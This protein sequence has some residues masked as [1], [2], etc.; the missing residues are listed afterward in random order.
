MIE[1]GRT[2]PQEGPVDD[3]EGFKAYYLSHDVFVLRDV[4]AR[5]ETNG[6]GNSILGAFYVKP[7]FPGRCDHICNH[8]FL[9]PSKYRGKGIGSFLAKYSL[10]LTKLLGYKAVYYN[11]VFTDNVY[12][13]HMYKKLGFKQTGEASS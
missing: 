13:I 8:G 5:E 1:E 2:Y 3:V 4:K 7:N 6:Q 10:P 9:V 11:L 12:A